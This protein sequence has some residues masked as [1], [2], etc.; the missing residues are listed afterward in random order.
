MTCC[1]VRS[2]RRF[3]KQKDEEEHGHYSVYD[4][5]NARVRAV[6]G[7]SAPAPTMLSCCGWQLQPCSHGAPLLPHPCTCSPALRLQTPLF[8]FQNYVNGENLDGEDVVVWAMIGAQVRMR[9]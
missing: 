3:T 5:H 2:A 7:T 6:G 9:G 1:P 8:S 4:F